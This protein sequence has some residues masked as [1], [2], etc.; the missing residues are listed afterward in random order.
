MEG[1]R[2]GISISQDIVGCGIDLAVVFNALVCA[3]C[4]C[5]HVCA[6]VCP[7]VCGVCVCSVLCCLCLETS[8]SVWAHMYVHARVHVCSC[9]CVCMLSVC[10]CGV[11]VR[12]RM[13]CVCM[14]AAGCLAHVHWPTCQSNLSDRPAIIVV[15]LCRLERPSKSSHF[16]DL[17]WVT[18]HCSGLT[19][20]MKCG[21]SFYLCDSVAIEVVSS[22]DKDL[23]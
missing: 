19:S 13:L 6:C 10:A 11:C 2:G 16:S 18:W 5:V 23:F 4:L 3:V 9:A 15:I 12:S 14:W 7:S 20:W 21:W 8:A 1:G 22:V 17:W